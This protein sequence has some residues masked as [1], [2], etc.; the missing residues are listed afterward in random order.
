MI[1]RYLPDRNIFKHTIS[2]TPFVIFYR[3]NTDGDEIV[4]LAIFYG[5]Q[6]R[7]EFEIGD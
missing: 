4:V 3:I 1:G 2:R 5:S 7:S 6:D